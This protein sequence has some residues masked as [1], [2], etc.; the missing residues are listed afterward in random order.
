MINLDSLLALLAVP[1]DNASLFSLRHSKKAKRLILKHSIRN[2]LEIV[3]PRFYDD[4]WVLETVTTSKPK[5]EKRLAEIKEA[6]TELKPTSIRLPLTG[7][8]WKVIYRETN[9]KDF[10]V[11]TETPTTLEVS[12]KAEDV[13]WT[14]TVLQEWLHG[15]A[16]QYLPKYLHHVSTKLKLPYNKMRIKRQ[17]TRWGSCSIKGN[18]NLNRNLMLMPSEVVDYVLHHELVH[19]KVLSHSSK[20]WKELERSFPNYKKSLEQL[21]YFEG[22]KI[23]EWALV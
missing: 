14:T 12:E 11:I 1:G 19:L 22:D 18:I 9:D 16:L 8:S 5:I 3:L 4:N 6:R 7:S 2:G 20:F 21:K 17:K 23:P 10:D 13:F 15:K